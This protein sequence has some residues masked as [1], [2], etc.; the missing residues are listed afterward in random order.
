MRILNRAIVAGALVVPMALGVSGVAVADVA[1]GGSVLPTQIV[2]SED[3]DSD[4]CEDPEFGGD[5][6]AEGLL[7][8]I[9]GN[10][11]D[12]DDDECGG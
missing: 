2:A 4:H 7:D 9:L 5:G 12:S 3:G 10:G 11:D 1:A 6:F 8:A